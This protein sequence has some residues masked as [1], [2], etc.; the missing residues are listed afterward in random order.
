MAGGGSSEVAE[1][2]NMVKEVIAEM[3]ARIAELEKLVP[4]ESV[5]GGGG[6]SGEKTISKKKPAGKKGK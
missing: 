3:E 4:A 5:P 6:T 1:L 2:R